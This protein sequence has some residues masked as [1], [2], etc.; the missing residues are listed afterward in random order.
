[1]KK[2]ILLVLALGIYTISLGQ[3]TSKTTTILIETK[4]AGDS[5]ITTK[6]TTTIL[7]GKTTTE[8]EVTIE[9]NVYEPEQALVIDSPKKKTARGISGFNLNGSFLNDN[10]AL[11]NVLGMRDINNFN[12]GFEFKFG[13][14]TKFN[15]ETTFD[16]GFEGGTN[17]SNN[18]QLNSQSAFLSLN[19]GYP[20]INY[21]EKFMIVP[22]VGV[23]Y[24][25]NSLNYVRT[26][27]N[28]LTI[29]TIAG[30]AWTVDNYTFYV[31]LGLEF[32]F[33]G[34]STYFTLGGEYRYAFYNSDTYLS[35]SKQKVSDFPAF[36][37]NNI[38]IKLT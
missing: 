16:F 4:Y 12:F 8:S 5:T 31:P 22:R 1:M 35:L 38:A 30:N 28:N 15:L 36:G 29:A 20:I 17:K 18:R 23:G 10:K 9:R 13:V 21:K 37:L 27:D 26:S 3:S 2:T 6:T 24:N 33:G 25:G 34:N 19:V 14:V 11:N 7:D 32:R